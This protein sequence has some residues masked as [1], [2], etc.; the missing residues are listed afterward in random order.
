MN[1]NAIN[2]M[3]Y[4]GVRR[5][6]IKDGIKYGLKR[7]VHARQSAGKDILVTAG[8][9]GASIGAA[10]FVK[11]TPAAQEFLKKVGQ[12][13]TKLVPEKVLVAAKNYGTKALNWVKGLPGP[14]KAAGAIGLAITALLHANNRCKTYYDQGKMEQEYRDIS[15]R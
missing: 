5:P 9:I 10:A 13:A 12:R 4:E 2:Q 15:R 1:I 14:A 11:N 7:T 6:S 8:G 3:Q